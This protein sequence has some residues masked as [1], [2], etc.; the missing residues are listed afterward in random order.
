MNSS[1]QKDSMI[2]ALKG[3]IVP[4]IKSLGFSG[5]FPHFRRKNNER[6]EFVSFQFNRHGGSFILECSFLHPQEL[7]DFFKNLPFE[8]L[9]CGNAHPKNRLRIKPQTVTVE[10][11]WFVYSKFQQEVQFDTLAKSLK[12][13]IPHIDTY[14]RAPK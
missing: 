7:S 10:D 8:Q 11:F 3:S 4:D 13:L 5:H 6:F 12:A 9:N 14:F 2:E 1:Q